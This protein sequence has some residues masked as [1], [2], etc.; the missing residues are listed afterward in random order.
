MLKTVAAGTSPVSS[1]FE[2]IQQVNYAI[3]CNVIIDH[4]LGVYNGGVSSRDHY[5]SDYDHYFQLYSL[6]WFLLTGLS[7]RIIQA[8]F[9]MVF[10]AILLCCKSL[11]KK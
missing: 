7:H 8:C 6:H 1:T 10:K 9:I 2:L 11:N 3:D 5:T 4:D